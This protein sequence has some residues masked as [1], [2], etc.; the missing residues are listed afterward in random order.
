M[1]IG[2]FANAALKRRCAARSSCAATSAAAWARCAVGEQPRVLE[3]LRDAVGELARSPRSSRSKRRSRSS[4]AKNISPSV[5]PDARSG[6]SMTDASVSAASSSRDLGTRRG[7]ALEQLGRAGS[8]RT[9]PPAC[10]AGWL[11]ASARSVSARCASARR[12]RSPDDGVDGGDIDELGAARLLVDASRPRTGLRAPGTT[13][14]V[15]DARDVRGLQ[16]ALEHARGLG[17]HARAAPVALERRA[18]LPLAR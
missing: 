2:A 6:T 18:R 11:V 3:R 10:S 12:T 4:D 14:C 8:S 15:I 16:R 13:S 1:P 9:S 7:P 17:Q 5:R